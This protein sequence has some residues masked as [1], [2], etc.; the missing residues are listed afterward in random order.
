MRESTLVLLF[1]D[2]PSLLLVGMPLASAYARTHVWPVRESLS[3]SLTNFTDCR[4]GKKDLIGR[5]PVHFHGLTDGGRNSWAD[6][7]AVHHSS[8]RC[9]VV[10]CTDNVVVSNN[11]C[12]DVAGF[13]IMLVSL[14]FSHSF[15]FF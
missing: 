1:V 15:V 12:F 14:L 9:I 3:T 11:F 4:F 13:G 2:N 10:H 5:Y 8:H 6:N 7:V